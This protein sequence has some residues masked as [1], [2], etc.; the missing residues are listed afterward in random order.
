MFSSRG[1]MT[2]YHHYVVEQYLP[3]K[4]KCKY[5]TR[6]KSW[7]FWHVDTPT[8]TQWVFPYDESTHPVRTSLTQEK[9][10]TPL[11]QLLSFCSECCC[12]LLAPTAIATTEHSLVIVES[13]AQLW[14]TKSQTFVSKQ[15]KEQDV[16][17][18]QKTYQCISLTDAMTNVV[19]FQTWFEPEEEVDTEKLIC[20]QILREKY[21]VWFRTWAVHH[22]QEASLYTFYYRAANE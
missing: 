15:V 9:R 20:Y 13:F 17:L 4:W 1:A 8:K 7:Y 22:W 18:F 5:S 11:H 21:S 19:Q 3:D 14:N 12:Q 2:P 6:K 16:V 10:L